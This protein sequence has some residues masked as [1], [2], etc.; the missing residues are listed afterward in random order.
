MSWLFQRVNHRYGHKKK[1][2]NQKHINKKNPTTDWNF[3]GKCWR[4]S[5]GCVTHLSSNIC[6]MMPVWIAVINPPLPSHQV[7]LDSFH[8]V[9]LNGPS[10]SDISV[11]LLLPSF[12]TVVIS[13]WFRT[14]SCSAELAP[15]TKW[16]VDIC[17]DVPRFW[18]RI[19]GFE[20]SVLWMRYAFSSLLY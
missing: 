16:T 2:K 20:V 5:A 9:E 15:W 4:G 18:H 11:T 7:Y 6:R 3:K 13:P 19:C 8:L 14:I 17:H 12:Q 10:V 1:R